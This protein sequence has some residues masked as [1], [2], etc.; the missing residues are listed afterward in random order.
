MPLPT[1]TPSGTYTPTEVVGGIPVSGSPTD[2]D[3]LLY[4]A[5]SNTWIPGAAGGGFTDGDKGDVVVSGTGAV[6]TIDTDA[7][8]YAQMQNVSATSRVLGRKTSGAGDPE[9]CSL[10]D[11]LD[12]IGGATQGDILYRGASGWSRLGAG[13][14]GY[15]LQTQGASANPAWA[16]G[17]VSLD[18]ILTDGENVITGGGNVLTT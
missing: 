16:A 18:T 4:D 1:Y 3:A 5:G 13:T 11:I 15:F 12:F 7:V 8:T 10:S 14:S 2:G 17:G 6:W 9:E